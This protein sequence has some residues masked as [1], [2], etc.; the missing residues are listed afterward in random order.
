MKKFK[1][2]T[3]AIA[4]AALFSSCKQEAETS[5]A[6]KNF[7]MNDKMYG[8]CTFATA[9]TQPVKQE[10]RLFGKIAADNNKLA[11][12]FPAVGGNVTAINAELGDY[13]EQGKILATMRSSEVADLQRQTNNA[14]A[15]VAIA[16]KNFQTANDLYEGKL[17]SEKELVQAKKELEKARAEKTRM[18][19]VKNI[20]RLQNGSTYNLYAPISGYVVSKDISPNEV[21]SNN[22][23]QSVFSI[24]KLD[25]VWVLANVSESD[26]SKV[27]TGQSVTIQT[28]AYPDKKIK[29][30][31]DKI[32]SVIDPETK[33]AKAMVKVSNPD[34]LLKPEMNATVT[35]NYNE[36]QNYIAVP[37]SAI[38]FDNSKNY[39]M[40][41]NS[42]DHIDTREVTVY[43][44]FDDVTYIS[45]GLKE[46]EK[47]IN[48]GN[49][50]IY[51]AIND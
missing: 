42:K 31:I 37:S 38:V 14:D 32:F 27:K 29:G 1:I 16:E 26:L 3:V 45:A 40:V 21:L 4:L 13:V 5:E 36:A 33:A 30:K 6:P 46:G 17:A 24:A 15:D 28:I 49:L 8:E 39:V 34:V 23:D 25:E 48:K 12:V 19:E 11:Q 50:L 47:I 51:D 20:Y 22:R 44:A 10:I 35:L 18:G 9:Q 2:F 41:F 7:V 43:R